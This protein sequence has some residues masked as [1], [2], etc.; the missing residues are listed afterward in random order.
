M[1]TVLA[2]AL[3]QSRRED[4]D[5]DDQPHAHYVHGRR[6]VYQPFMKAR[7]LNDQW[8]V[9]SICQCYVLSHSWKPKIEEP[10][11]EEP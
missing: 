4:K 11:I 6:R 9:L 5:D 2:R 1:A 3:A 8:S 10:K 7:I